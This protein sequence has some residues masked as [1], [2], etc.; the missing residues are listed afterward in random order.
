MGGIAIGL[1]LPM[2]ISLSTWH[3]LVFVYILIASVVPVWALLQPR[4][5]LNSYLLII[6]IAAA[7]LGVFVANL[8]LTYQ[9]M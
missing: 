5:Y 6:M 4:D 7:V 3:I 1:A 8:P 9:H 2:Y